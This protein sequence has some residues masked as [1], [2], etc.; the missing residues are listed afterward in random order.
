MRFQHYQMLAELFRYP[1]EKFLWKVEVA[2]NWLNE[3]CPAAAAEFEKIRAHPYIEPASP[4]WPL[5]H[6][7]LARAAA[8]QGDR[9]KSR[10]WYE[11]FFRLW[12]N[13]DAELPALRAAREEFA[14][15]Q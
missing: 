8:L 12:Q 6:L 15:L 5:A 14:R 7:G 11:E 4:L 3:F 13:A 2:R 1:E 10:Q 9:V